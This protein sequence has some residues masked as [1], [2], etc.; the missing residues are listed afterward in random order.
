MNALNTPFGF[1][2]TDGQRVLSLREGRHFRMYPTGRNRGFGE[3]L[4]KRQIDLLR[5]CM[6]IH[7]AD[8]WVRRRGWTNGRRRLI[9]DVEVL[10]A[11]FWSQPDTYARLKECVDFL[12]GGDDWCFR[13]VHPTTTRHDRCANLFRGHDLCALVTLYSGGLDSATGLAARLSAVKG[14]MVIPVT[15]RHQMQ[16]GKLI[17]DHFNLLTEHG[18]VARKDRQPLQV[19]AFI[20]N[21][22]IKRELGVRLREVTHR[23]RP[24]LFMSVA[25]LVASTV[26]ASEVEVFESGVGSVNLPL[27]NGPADYHTTRSTNPHYLR[28]I[29]ELV[30][31]VNDAG[32]RFVL[33]FADFTKAEMVKRAKELGLEELARKSVSC[34]LH[35]L[36]RP[37]NRQCG[38]CPACVYRRQAMITAGITESR[39]AYDIDLFSPLSTATEKQ[40]Q[41]IRAYHQQA[42]RLAELEAERVPKFFRSYL[43]AT[44]A[45]S[46][47]CELGPHVEVYR[48]YQREWAAL[49]ADARRHRLPWIT[50]ARLLTYAE[51]ATP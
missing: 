16:K 2:V 14:R 27:V 26:A 24:I 32:V 46:Q 36:R 31:H 42:G 23:C 20:R 9:V 10:D 19:G 13:F 18:L 41:W 5:I 49:I 48:R 15:L 28:L 11:P 45:V 8:G 40:L 6:A 43:Y 30:S 29:S 17:R 37:G 21:K 7:A 51:G 22:R 1:T 39:D 4:T 33:P 12:S 3:E 34:I 35:P 47:D 50:P 38:Y 44:Q 25:G